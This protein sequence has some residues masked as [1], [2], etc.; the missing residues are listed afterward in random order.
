[1][2]RDNITEKLKE[3]TKKRVKKEEVKKE[4]VKKEEESIVVHKCIPTRDIQIVELAEP[5]SDPIFLK[6]VKPDSAF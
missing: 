4:E 1:M 6:T 5:D 3:M 2:E